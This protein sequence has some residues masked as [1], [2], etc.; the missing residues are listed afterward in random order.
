MLT[1][2]GSE[3]SR[4]LAIAVAV[5]TGVAIEKR[6]GAIGVMWTF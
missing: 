3:N 6:E 5:S 2:I 4:I 1:H